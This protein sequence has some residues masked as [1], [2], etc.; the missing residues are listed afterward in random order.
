[1]QRW[2]REFIGVRMKDAGGNEMKMRHGLRSQG[3]TEKTVW[4][5]GVL[6][7][8]QFAAIQMVIPAF[9]GDKEVAELSPEKTVESYLSAAQKGDFEAAYQYVSKG[10]AQNKS[11]EAWAKEQLTI[12][13]FSELKIL[14]FQ[15]FP[16]KVEEEKAYVPNIL[17]SKDNFINKLGVIEHELYPLIRED[18]RWKID[19]QQVVEN[20]DKEKWFPSQGDGK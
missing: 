13:Q 11:R 15:V 12:A 10:M 6:A 7:L 19:Q 1:M 17:N 16:A 18:K 4:V 14:E 8:V 2:S 5:L 9:A 3:M 20:R